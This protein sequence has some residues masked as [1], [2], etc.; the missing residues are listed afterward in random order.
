MK[1][2]FTLLYLLAL[3]RLVLPFLL[4]HPSYQPHRDEFLY[5]DYA[6]AMD[7]GYMEVPPLISIFSWLNLQFGNGFFWIKFWPA[8]AGSLTFLLTGL[9]VL[10]WGGNR[11]GLIL[12][13]LSSIFG[14][15]LRVFFLFQPGFLEVL[16]WTAIFFC[17]LQYQAS[18][19]TKWLYA[20]GLCCGLGMLSKYT[21]AF[22][23]AGLVGG[24]LISNQRSILQNL[25]FWVATVLALIIFLPNFLWQYHHNFPVVNH[26]N[27]LRETQLVHMNA[28]GFITGQLLMNIVYAFVWITGLA[29]IIFSKEWKTFGWVVY[30][31]LIVIVLL[32]AGSGKDYYALGLY[33]VLFAFGA[34]YIGKTSLNWRVWPKAALLTVSI[35][36]GL[37]I[38]PVL[39]PVFAPGK[40]AEYYETAGF[41]KALGFTWE[42]QENHPLPQDF[43]DMLGWK[44]LTNMA[45]KNFN[46][47]PD[48]I[49]AETIIFCRG[50]YSAG[51]LNYYGKNLGLPEAYTDNGSYLLR[52][53]DS[54]SFK[55]L[56]LVAH[57]NPG[58]DDIVFNH[59]E[60]RF[61]M[62][63]LQL[64]LFR[65][66]GIRIYFFE[67]GSDSMRMLATQG[68]REEKSKFSRT[69]D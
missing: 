20:F 52:L 21:T 31:Y 59:F 23:I 65:E 63:S 37:F 3:V 58:P 40:L 62:D 68:I 29:A 14:A 45:A 61:V 53:P 12:L 46:K 50:Y 33:P 24:I 67:N 43:A 34:A 17:F 55:H 44:E 25:H 64:P 9:L 5:L 60:K 26:M 49:K 2:N 7:W 4:Q 47:W 19:K 18:R 35:L 66:N 32:I 36:A 8:L 13:F 57:Q 51:A 15:F 10:Q 56:M 27:E 41:R 42:D 28:L 48:S 22:F 30:C 11:F 6:H 69:K 39:I 16:S 1:N 54:F 38:W